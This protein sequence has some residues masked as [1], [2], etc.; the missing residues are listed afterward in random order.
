MANY[1]RELRMGG[2]LRRKEKI[3]KTVEFTERMRKMQE[4]VGAALTKAQEEIKKQMDRERKKAKVW[5]VR[6]KVMLS[7]KYLVF[8]EQPVK[9]LVDEYMG[10]YLINEVVSTNADKL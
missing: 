10:L 6:N 9:K 8:K 2:N 7:M 1:G 4:E 5:K 3:E